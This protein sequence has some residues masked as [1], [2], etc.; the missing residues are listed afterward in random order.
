MFVAHKP[1][2]DVVHTERNLDKNALCKNL[3]RRPM[4]KHTGTWWTRVRR[5]TYR[6]YSHASDGNRDYDGDAHWSIITRQWGETL[7]SEQQW[8]TLSSVST[9]RLLLMKKE[10]DTTQSSVTEQKNRLRLFFNYIFHKHPSHSRVHRHE[11]NSGHIKWTRAQWK[12][13][14][15][16]PVTKNPTL[17]RPNDER[18]IQINCWSVQGLQMP[19]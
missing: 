15:M 4:C 5:M 9:L 2:Q 7:W 19:Q 1:W 11:S 18:A 17:A 16:H 8:S 14:V 6:M 12:H 10:Q 13:T 3:H